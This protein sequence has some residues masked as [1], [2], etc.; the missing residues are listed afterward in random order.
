ME[1]LIKA[2]NEKTDQFIILLLFLFCEEIMYTLVLIV[3]I[4]C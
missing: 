4:M 3:C 2:I 1:K